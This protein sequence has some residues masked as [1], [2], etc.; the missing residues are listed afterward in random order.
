MQTPNSNANKKATVNWPSESPRL[1][2]L[3]AERGRVEAWTQFREDRELLERLRVTSDELEALEKCALLGTLTCKQ[4]LLFI[5]RQIR[6]ATG[7]QAEPAVVAAPLNGARPGPVG[8]TDSGRRHKTSRAPKT[9]GAASLNSPSVMLRR[10]STEH[11]LLVISAIVAS[12]GLVW[13][14]FAGLYALSEHLFSAAGGDLP[15]TPPLPGLG[16]VSFNGGVNSLVAAEI[17]FVAIFVL[18]LSYSRWKAHR[19]LKSYREGYPA[20][21]RR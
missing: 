3:T 17:V 12:T 8:A 2:A 5:L 20:A 9:A 4:D 10:R 21:S 7:S 14:L 11:L 19:R 16:S 15:D 18:L 6:E 13:G 1:H